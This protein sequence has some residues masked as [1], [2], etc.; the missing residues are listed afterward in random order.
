[1]FS[2]FFQAVHLSFMCC[3]TLRAKGLAPASVWL[4]PVIYLTHS[5]RPAYPRLM[6]E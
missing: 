3:I 6:V 2:A 1:M 5:Y 4:L